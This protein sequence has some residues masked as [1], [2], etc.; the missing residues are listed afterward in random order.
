MFVKRRGSAKR[1]RRTY[2]AI[3]FGYDTS[4]KQ[5]EKFLEGFGK[6]DV[7]DDGWKY[8]IRIVLEGNRR[9]GPGQIMLK[10]ERQKKILTFDLTI[11]YDWFEQVNKNGQGS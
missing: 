8:S 4:I 7:I 1:K 6:V 10:D 3:E 5:T 2:E 9:V 11:F